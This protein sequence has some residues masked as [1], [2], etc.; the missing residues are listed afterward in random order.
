MKCNK[1]NNNLRVGDHVKVRYN[2]YW[3][4][5]IVSNIKP[6][7]V[8]HYWVN[9]RQTEPFIQESRF[10]EFMQDQSDYEV[11]CYCDTYRF[12]HNDSHMI[13]RQSLGQTKY[14][15]LTN[16]CEHFATY[17]ITGDLTSEQIK[18][19]STGTGGASSLLLCLS[20]FI[21]FKFFILSTSSS[22]SL[23][24][25]RPRFEEYTICAS[26]YSNNKIKG[27]KT[28]TVSITDYETF[29]DYLM[30]ELQVH[31][32]MNLDKAVIFDNDSETWFKLTPKKITSLPP[33]FSIRL[34]VVKLHYE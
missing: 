32:L 6:R 16:N 22:G 34:Y 25:C 1:C 28:L 10:E 29:I 13:A 31:N 12:N 26:L 30:T 9:D 18:N 27:I 8:I 11:V 7:M 17:C 5:G 19:G 4:H 15:L 3:H 2:I 20:G 33:T 14:N 21:S 24:L 23:C